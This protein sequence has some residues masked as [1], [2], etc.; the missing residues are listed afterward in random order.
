MLVNNECPKCG[1]KLQ[2]FSAGDVLMC[3]ILC[4]FIMKNESARKIIAKKKKEE[5]VPGPADPFETAVE[6][7]DSL[8]S[9][10]M[11]GYE[12]DE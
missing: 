11:Y 6:A 10:V 9:D 4:G 1:D 12:D 3:S 5:Y 8:G 2:Y 7:V